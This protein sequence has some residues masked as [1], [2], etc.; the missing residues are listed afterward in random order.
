MDRLLF[1]EMKQGTV[2]IRCPVEL[3]CFYRESIFLEL[4]ISNLY[5]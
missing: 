1:I 2:G 5:G 3:S 4:G